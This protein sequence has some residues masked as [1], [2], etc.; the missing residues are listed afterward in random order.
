MCSPTEVVL[1]AN[2]VLMGP[3]DLSDPVGG[4]ATFSVRYL[5][6]GEDRMQ[7]VDRINLHPK[8]KATVQKRAKRLKR[9]DYTPHNLVPRK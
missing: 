5:D 3:W 8:W 1:D 4:E 9:N 6:T 7:R 2:T